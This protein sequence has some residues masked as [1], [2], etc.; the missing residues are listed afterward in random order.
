MGAVE[1]KS[2]ASLHPLFIGIM[3]ISSL[4]P[5]SKKGSSMRILK[6]TVIAAV[7]GAAMLALSL[8]S[9]SAFTLSGPS[10]EQPVASAQVE[11]VWWH[12]G[13]GGGW[14]GGWHHG[15][16]GGWG[17]GYGPGWG[18]RRWCYWHPGACY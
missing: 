14:H 12:H 5:Q 17:G 9:A 13:W 4:G 3:L 2:G 10:L 7:G 1:A 6:S 8:S 11:K 15:W 18:H 16:G